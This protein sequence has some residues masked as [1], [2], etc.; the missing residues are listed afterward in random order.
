MSSFAA[1]LGV[2]ELWINREALPLSFQVSPGDG[3]ALCGL[4]DA[5]S[6]DGFQLD[7]SVVPI[8]AWRGQSSENNFLQKI[9]QTWFF[10]QKKM[11]LVILLQKENDG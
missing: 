10:S 6:P 5:S 8:R 1:Y 3:D 2:D 11:V 7:S 9:K 4:I